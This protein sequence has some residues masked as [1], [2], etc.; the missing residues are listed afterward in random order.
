MI[1][2][3]VN[4]IEVAKNYD[5]L[6]G[7]SKLCIEYLKNNYFNNVNVCDVGSGTGILIND[8]INLNINI[9]SVEPD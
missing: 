6:P 5:K 1:K 4:N 9:F 7:Y 8:L 3:F 2:K